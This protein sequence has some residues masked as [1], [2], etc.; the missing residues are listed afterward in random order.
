MRI[1]SFAE[2]YRVGQKSLPTKINL[3]YYLK[4]IKLVFPSFDFLLRKI[5]GKKFLPHP[6]FIIVVRER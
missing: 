6:V 5:G 4:L 3:F 1:D 2:K